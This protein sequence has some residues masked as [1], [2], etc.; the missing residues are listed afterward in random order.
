MAAG[1]VRSPCLPRDYDKNSRSALAGR[2]PID[3][4][5]VRN[6]R[7]GTVRAGVGSR[8]HPADG[9]GAMLKY[10]LHAGRSHGTRTMTRE[11][12]DNP[13]SG[14]VIL[15]FVRCQKEILP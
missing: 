15:R 13:L 11:L 12:R 14:E 7:I 2:A 6:G 4:E 5:C 10:R 8:P 1:R 3:P 9:S